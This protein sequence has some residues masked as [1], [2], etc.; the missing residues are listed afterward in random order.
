MLRLL[1]AEKQNI[2]T[3][4]EF[5]TG[6]TIFRQNDPDFDLFVIV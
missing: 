3:L 6:E 5:H 2:S 4:C 1:I